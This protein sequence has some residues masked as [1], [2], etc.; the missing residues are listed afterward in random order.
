MLRSQDHPMNMLQ[1]LVQELQVREEPLVLLLLANS[2]H[3][4]CLD[5]WLIFQLS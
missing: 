4:R 1:A 5:G 3:L 2:Q